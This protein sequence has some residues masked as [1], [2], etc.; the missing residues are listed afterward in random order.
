MAIKSKT[1]KPTYTMSCSDLGSPD[2]GFSV[3]THSINEIKKAT[4]AHAK[5][6]HPEML[7]NMSEAEKQAML[8]KIDKMLMK[9]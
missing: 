9:K 1:P 6:T 4:F 7:A 3:T 8:A 2:C 5:Y